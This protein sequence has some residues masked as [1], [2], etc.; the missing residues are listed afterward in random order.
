MAS[1]LDIGTKPLLV[2]NPDHSLH[3]GRMNENAGRVR[4][5]VEALRSSGRWEQCEIL[6]TLVPSSPTEDVAAVLHTAHHLASLRAAFGKASGWFC[7]VCTLENVE[8]A[9]ECEVCGTE[10]A[11][12]GGYAAGL[13]NA[14]YALFAEEGGEFDSSLSA[15]ARSSSVMECVEVETE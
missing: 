8:G 12:P 3:D 9:T 11:A 10:R 7:A 1:M 5:A 14:V 6:T 4:A 2:Y 13:R 15:P